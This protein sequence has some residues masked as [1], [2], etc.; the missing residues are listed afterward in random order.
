MLDTPT[1]HASGHA[2][3]PSVARIPLQQADAAS[4]ESVDHWCDSRRS[5]GSSA[6]RLTISSSCT[7]CPPSMPSNGRCW[8]SPAHRGCISS[9]T[10]RRSSSAGSVASSAPL[11]GLA[12]SAHSFENAATNTDVPLTC[13]VPPLKICEHL[14][15]LLEGSLNRWLPERAGN[16]RLA[17]QIHDSDALEG[18]PR[19]AA[20]SSYIAA[21][22]DVALVSL[23]RLADTPPTGRAPPS[24]R[25]PPP[26]RASSSAPHVPRRRLHIGHQIAD[27]GGALA[28]SLARPSGGRLD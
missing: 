5:D 4:S 11:L 20:V 28:R 24:V 16:A 2:N 12:R 10:I 18:S 13:V 9:A 23:P 17:P 25:Q 3:G 14:L 7:D 21:L 19:R 1:A 22:A 27:R 26:R 15:L 6:S 8:F